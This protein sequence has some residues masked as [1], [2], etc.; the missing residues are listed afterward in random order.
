[1]ALRGR[2]E[3]GQMA[4]LECPSCSPVGMGTYAHM[5]NY[6]REMLL[7]REDVYRI[8]TTAST[9]TEVAVP[10]ATPARTST[11]KCTPR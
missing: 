8:S 5:S 3:I 4:Q 10:M 9:T 11:G 6:R 1:M 2:G 7:Q